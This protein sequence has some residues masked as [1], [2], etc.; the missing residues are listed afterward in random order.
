[1]TMPRT[2]LEELESLE[3]LRALENG[4]TILVAEVDYSGRGID[5]PQDYEAFVAEQ[6]RTAKR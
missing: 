1:M 6:S 2:P 3:Q 4:H 5:T